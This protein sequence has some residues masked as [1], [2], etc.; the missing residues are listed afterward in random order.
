MIRLLKTDTAIQILKS[1]NSD[2]KTLVY[3]MSYGLTIER[4]MSAPKMFQVSKKIGQ[5]NLIKL[6][7]VIIKSFCDSVKAKQS[8]DALDIFECSELL[9][10][11]YTHDSVKDI[12][13][14]LKDAKKDGKTIYNVIT[15]GIIFEIVGKYMENKTRFIERCEADAKSKNDGSVRTE[16]YSIAVGQERSL[17]RKE[18]MFDNKELKEIQSEK[19][20]IKKIQNLI[21]KTV[22]KI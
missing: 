13:M 17:Q 21:E 4:A 14:A 22:E 6:L 5:E 2:V 15:T 18:K 8:M 3:E 19:K 9:S 20:E 1:Q 16:A 10:E 11:T 7:C 12:V